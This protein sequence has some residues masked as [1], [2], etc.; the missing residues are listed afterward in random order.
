[1]NVNGTNPV[2]ATD[3]EILAGVRRHMAGVEV[4]VPAPPALNPNELRGRAMGSSVR[5]RVAFAG[6][7][8]LVL[9]AILIVVAVGAGLGARQ[10]NGTGPGGST[11]GNLYQLIYRLQAANG[12]QITDA[13]LDGTVAIVK[14]RLDSTGAAGVAVSKRSPDEIVVIVPGSP[15]I[16][17]IE[18][19]IARSGSLTFVPL[20]ADQYGSY[21]SGGPVMPSGALALPAPGDA[22]QSTLPALLDGGDIDRAAS[23]THAMFD[24][25][26]NVWAVQ[27]GL[28]AAGTDKIASWSAGHVGDY[29]AIVLDD[30]VMEV[31]FIQAP[32]SDGILQIEGGLTESSAKSLATVLQYG[33]LPFPLAL[34]SA[35]ILRAGDGAATAAATGSPSKSAT[36][37]LAPIAAPASFTAT[38]L[39]ASGRSLGNSAAPVTVDVWGDYQCA[40]CKSFAQTVLPQLVTKYVAS[41]K[42]RVVF[43]DFIVID[44]NVGGHESADAANAALCAADQNRFWDYQDWLWVNQGAEGSGS[45]SVARLVEIGRQAGLDMTKF[46]PCV[47]GGTHAS[48]VQAETAAVPALLVGTPSVEVNGV[49]AAAFDYDTVAAAIDAALGNGSVPSSD[50]A[51]PTPTITPAIAPLPSN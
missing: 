45:F 35:Q 43:H 27:V 32:I 44:S 36:T 34:E 20:P 50:Q 2:E 37:S 4:L 10:G 41:G 16:S 9:V 29:L 8:P 51:Q 39:P 18:D 12:V 48:D 23:Q 24:T 38:G 33:L 30:R 49:L 21:T 6:L 1:M 22:F 15:N 7:A 3:E 47:E 5:S 40:A 25:T 31:P 42:V 17:Q 28:N 46:Q 26:T 11:S 13:D 19:L 14:N